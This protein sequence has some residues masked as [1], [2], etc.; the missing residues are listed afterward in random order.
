MSPSTYE[1]PAPKSTKPAVDMKVLGEQLHPSY[2]DVDDR[3]LFAL[4]IN[5]MSISNPR[6]SECGR[7][8]VNPSVYGLTEQQADMLDTVNSALDEAVQAGLNEA[9]RKIQ[10]AC[11]VEF[12]DEAAMFFSDSSRVKAFAEPLVQYMLHELNL[13]LAEEQERPAA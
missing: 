5:G 6:I 10:E 7:F 12:G 13:Q 9:C 2:S 4:S 8:D 11:G 3:W 1:I